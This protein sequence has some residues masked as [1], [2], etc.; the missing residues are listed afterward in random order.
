MLHP[1]TTNHCFL[2]YGGAIYVIAIDML[3]MEM[4]MPSIGLIVGDVALASYLV[5]PACHSIVTAFVLCILL[6]RDARLW[7]LI[8]KS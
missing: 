3:P 2:S 1:A 8:M 7:S 5:P 6:Y 4:I